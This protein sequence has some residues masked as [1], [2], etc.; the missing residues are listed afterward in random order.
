MARRMSRG[1]HRKVGHSRREK[2][3]RVVWEIDLTAQTPHEAAEQALEIQRD[4]WS[5]STVFTVFDEDGKRHWIDL[6]AQ[7]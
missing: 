6:E 2:G 1:R 4:V 5:E 3:Y 7:S